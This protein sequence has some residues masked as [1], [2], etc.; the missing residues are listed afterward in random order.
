MIRKLD[1]VEPQLREVLLSILEEMEKQRKERVT[2]EEFRELRDIVKELAQAQRKTEEKVKELAQAQKKTEERMASLEMRMEE[3]AQAQ[4]K[5][6]EKVKELAQAQKKTEEEL[7]KL[8]GEHRKTREQLGGLSHTVGYVL[9]DRAYRGLPPLLKRDFGVEITEPLHRDFIEVGIGRYE[10]VNL[11]GKG[12][13]DGKEVIIVG[14]C[15]TQMKKKDIDSFLRVLQRIENILKG[16]KIVVGVTY[17]AT[18]PV[19][20]YAEEKG[21]KLYFSYEFPL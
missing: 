15:K 2:K 20:K 11:I 13:K 18:I 4:R 10:E 12:R 7:K 9:E 17:Q 5:T 14:D 16:E 1:K 21:I 8:I 6:E 19:R 3:L